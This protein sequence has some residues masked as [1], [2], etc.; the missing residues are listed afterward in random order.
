MTACL[1]TTDQVKAMVKAMRDAKVFT[2]VTDFKSAG[3]VSATYTQT[4]ERVF[5]ALQKG[6]KG[7]PWIVRYHPQLFSE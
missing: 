3:T 6:P 7:N 5:T 4:G 2:V 1:L